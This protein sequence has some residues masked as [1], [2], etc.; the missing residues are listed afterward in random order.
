MGAAISVMKTIALIT[1]TLGGGGAERTTIQLANGLAQQQDL[2]VYLLVA[3]TEGNHGQLCSEVDSAV[4]LV[5]FDCQSM[6]SMI[7]PL[8]AWLKCN[9]PNTIISTQT[10]TNIAVY[11]AGI[12]S[13][14][15]GKHICREVSTPSINLKHI[16]GV[17]CII[18]K[19]LMRW[20]YTRAYRVVAVSQG[21]A[22]DVQQY[23]GLKLSNLTVIYN[24]VITSKLFIDAQQPV[25]HPWFVPEH[26]V[27]VV[28]AVGRLTAAKN[29]P[30]LLR[31]F[32]Q[33][34]EH[35]SA[36]LVIL[37]E[38]EERV[39]LEQLIQQLNITS[40]VQLAGFDPN[41]YR[42]MAKCDVY[43]MSSNWEG[44]PGS[45]IQALALGAKVVSTDCPSGPREILNHGEY[46]VL[47]GCEQVEQLKQAIQ[48][49]LTIHIENKNINMN[50]FMIPTII[51]KYNEEILGNI[52]V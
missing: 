24:P 16:Q 43:V 34:L 42:Y 22:D 5:D 10:H 51:R 21:V 29:Y 13:N 19:A 20:V 11:L 2:I 23:L 32:A 48:K 28:L 36:H 17:K 8:R 4:K 52:N 26:K 35:I 14:Y 12:L 44:L 38:G 50:K 27:P 9:Q 47:V 41:P 1:P 33:L 30:L 18:L 6:T 49:Q 40:S 39:A 37:G 3:S 15:K 7:F 25:D 46:G 31:A 45:L